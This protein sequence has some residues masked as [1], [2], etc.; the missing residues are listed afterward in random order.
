MHGVARFFQCGQVFS[1]VLP[2][3]KHGLQDLNL[4]LPTLKPGLAELEPLVRP[5]SILGLSLVR[6]WLVLGLPYVRPWYILGG[7]VDFCL[8]LSLLSSVG[9]SFVCPWLVHFGATVRA[10]TNCRQK[11]R[12]LLRSRPEVLKAPV[13][14][15]TCLSPST[16][17]G[18]VGFPLLAPR[19]PQGTTWS[20]H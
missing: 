19:A 7:S 2:S 17:D 10:A 3:L 4:G 5:W 11:L 20:C 14:E 8:G 15:R 9:L 1:M 16:T 12:S 13:P 18:P 6:P